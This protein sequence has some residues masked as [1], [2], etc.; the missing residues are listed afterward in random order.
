[1]LWGTRGRGNRQFFFGDCQGREDTL[2]DS[3][4]G[5]QVVSCEVQMTKLRV[6]LSG[7]TLPGSLALSKGWCLQT[8][9]FGQ[10]F[11]VDSLDQI[12]GA[13]PS[14]AHASEVPVSGSEEGAVWE[15]QWT[16]PD[17]KAFLG[18]FRQM[19]TCCQRF[20]ATSAQRPLPKKR[21]IRNY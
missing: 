5:G 18:F 9:G 1:M 12:I 4:N 17:A 10:S 8:Q 20:I 16:D 3:A 11:A 14:A 15:V 7:F 2:P 6:C 21:I 19:M 13:P